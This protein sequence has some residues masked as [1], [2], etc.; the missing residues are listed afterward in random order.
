MD[1]QLGSSNIF[2][3]GNWQDLIISTY[4][5]DQSILKKYL[6]KNTELDLFNGKALMSIVA[7]TFSN[8]K[9]FGI[10]I[11][12]H[13]KF[14]QI[15]FRFYVKSKI[16]GAKGVVFIKEFAP[17]PLIA[18]T[19]NI[20]YNEPYFTKKI[21]LRTNTNC[22]TKTIKYSYK[23]MDVA[24]EIK[25]STHSLNKNSLEE[26]VVDRYIAF[27]KNRTGK[28]LQYRIR[29]RPWKLY[30]TIHAA[31]NDDL[32][33]LLPK[34]F[35]NIKHLKTYVVDGSSVLVEKG[36]LQHSLVKNIPLENIV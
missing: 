6:P 28:T 8:V 10:K 25:S 5:V 2:M 21:R 15:N 35:Q 23:Q 26:C 36:I 17:K 31:V 18:L 34:T 1:T 22:N 33:S 32:I 4:E 9:F 30:N 3:T 7:F 27:V 11:P 20:F 13:Q 16:N 29:H 24:A 14:G 19:A 12:F